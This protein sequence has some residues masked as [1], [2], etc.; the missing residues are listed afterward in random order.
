MQCYKILVFVDEF[1]ERFFGWFL[2]QK[3]CK[4]HY[5]NRFVNPEGLYSIVKR[6]TFYLPQLSYLPV[7][8]LQIMCHT[9]LMARHHY[10]FTLLL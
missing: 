1:W 9:E 6:A 5:L 7:F 4:Q 8:Y 2:Y 10:T 3:Y